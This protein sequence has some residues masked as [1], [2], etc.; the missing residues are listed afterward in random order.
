MQVYIGIVWLRYLCVYRLFCGAG[1]SELLLL[2][3]LL[4]NRFK[5]FMYSKCLWY[6]RIAEEFF[7]PIKSTLFRLYHLL[8]LWLGPCGGIADAVGVTVGI[9]VTVCIARFVHF[10]ELSTS[11]NTPFNFV[12]KNG[13]GHFCNFFVSTVANIGLHY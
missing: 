10:V 4:S 5:S 6:S 13:F 8:V 9:G 3:V 2:L 7:V 1:A 12:C 11:K